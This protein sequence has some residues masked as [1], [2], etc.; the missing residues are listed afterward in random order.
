MP[1]YQPVVGDWYRNANGDSFEV[2]AYELEDDS[3]ELQYFDGSLEELDLD[4]WQ[5]LIL[6]L[7]EPPDDYSVPLDMMREDY[8]N[9]AD[10]VVIDSGNYLDELD[11]RF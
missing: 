4:T 3:I 5:Q 8:P 6:E 7:A 10:G 2:V 1:Q 11:A 9:D